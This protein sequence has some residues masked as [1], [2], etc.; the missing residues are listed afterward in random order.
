MVPGTNGVTIA[1]AGPR[2][3]SIALLSEIL[4]PDAEPER[5]RTTFKVTLSRLRNLLGVANAMHL[6]DTRVALNHDIV[7]ADCERFDALA[8]V[9]ERLSSASPPNVAD[10]STTAPP[11]RF[12]EHILSIYAGCFLGDEPCNRWLQSSRVRW[13]ARFIRVVAQ[14]GSLIEA[15]EG[16]GEAAIRLYERAVEQDA[17]AEEQHRRLIAAYLQQGE[18]AQAMSVFLRLRHSLALLLGLMPSEKTLALIAPLNPVAEGRAAPP[19]AHGA[20]RLN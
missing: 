20:L 4:W 19:G 15:E 9:I 16:G 7:R 11:G 2:G 8:D 3:V 14:A 13:H 17:T 12:A 18:H 5:A 6:T 1:T 10:K